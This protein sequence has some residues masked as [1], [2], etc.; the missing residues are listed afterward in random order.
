MPSDVVL[1]ALG[2]PALRTSGF[3]LVMVM[4]KSAA[5]GA[6]ARRV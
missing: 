4:I 6:L 2:W 1:A 5:G 3:A